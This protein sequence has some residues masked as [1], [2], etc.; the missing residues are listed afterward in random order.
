M[1][2]NVPY[3][4]TWSRQLAVERIKWAAG[5]TFSFDDFV[6]NDSREYGDKFLTRGQTDVPWQQVTA[7][8]SPTH[9]PV[10]KKGS[11]TDYLKKKG[12]KR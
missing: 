11:I 9:G 3:F 12:G 1:N 2:N 6:A 8:H 7:T 5:E 10:I 4:S